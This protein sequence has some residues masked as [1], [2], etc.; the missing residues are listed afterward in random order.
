LSYEN[1]Q[2]R[3]SDQKIFISN[4]TKAN[5][6]LNWTPQVQAN[7]GIQKVIDWLQDMGLEHV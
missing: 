2:W 3:E 5:K 6:L 7:L 4:L 1:L